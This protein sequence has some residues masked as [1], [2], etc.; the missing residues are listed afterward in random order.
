MRQNF[1]GMYSLGNPQK[2]PLQI[3]TAGVGKL[4]F[5]PHKITR[6]RPYFYDCLK[7]ENHTQFS[8]KS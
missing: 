8:Q 2:Q 5:L 3:C 7:H 4:K 1:K 6:F